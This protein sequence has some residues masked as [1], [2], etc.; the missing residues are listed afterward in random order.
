MDCVVQISKRHVSSLR[1][2]RSYASD[3]IAFNSTQA[4]I[5]SEIQSYHNFHLMY[6]SFLLVAFRGSCPDHSIFIP[7]VVKFCNNF[8]IK[9]FEELI[10]KSAD[11]TD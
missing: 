2:L 3:S 8:T 9:S 5:P 1:D 7:V 4:H 6:N 11:L 10:G